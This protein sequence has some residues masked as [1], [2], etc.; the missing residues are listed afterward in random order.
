M[1]PGPSTLNVQDFLA[2]HSGIW[3]STL[4]HADRPVEVPLSVHY[5]LGPNICTHITYTCMVFEKNKFH[6]GNSSVQ[7]FIQINLTSV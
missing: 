5:R 2:V 3:P 7:A 4:V 1:I 6:P